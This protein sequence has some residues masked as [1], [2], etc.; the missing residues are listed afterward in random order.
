MAREPSAP[1]PLAWLVV[2]DGPGG[3]RGKLITLGPETV[4]GRTDADL[5]LSGDRSVSTQHAKVRLEPREEDAPSGAPPAKD[6]ETVFVLYD[7]AS[8]NGVFLGTRDTYRDESSRI[9]RAELED[10]DHILVGQTTL[11]FK[12]VA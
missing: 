1:I 2:T 4:V 6:V 3:K 8:T 5:L 12:Q 11:V 10:G 9:F 7:L